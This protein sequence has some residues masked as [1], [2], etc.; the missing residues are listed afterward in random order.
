MRPKQRLHR[1]V[2]RPLLGLRRERGKR[3]VCVERLAHRLRDVRHRVVARGAPG[4]PLPDLPGAVRG[5]PELGG[6]LLEMFQIHG[7]KVPRRELARN[8]PHTG[9]GSMFA[10]VTTYELAEGR[11]SEFEVG[12]RAGAAD[13]MFL[14]GSRVT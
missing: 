5:L 10:R 1:A 13:T 3:D 4:G 9:G 14:G 7:S 12:I 6:T 11:A 2:A 8:A